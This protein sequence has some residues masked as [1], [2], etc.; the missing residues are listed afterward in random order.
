MAEPATIAVG[1]AFAIFTVI[2]GL[3]G[4]NS[5]NTVDGDVREWQ[6]NE[7]KSLIGLNF[8]GSASMVPTII[9]SVMGLVCTVSCCYFLSGCFCFRPKPVNI[10]AWAAKRRLLE[11]KPSAPSKSESMPVLTEEP[12]LPSVHSPSPPPSFHRL[13]LTRS[14]LP[15]DARCFREPSVIDIEEP[16]RFEE[17]SSSPSIEPITIASSLN[18]LEAIPEHDELVTNSFMVRSHTLPN[19][20]TFLWI[21]PCNTRVRSESTGSIVDPTSPLPQT[22]ASLPTLLPSLLASHRPRLQ[23]K[24]PA[25]LYRARLPTSPSK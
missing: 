24:V 11:S 13:S 5:S 3:L 16:P 10:M 8:F 19:K 1:C 7:S 4:L 23:Y 21:P 17:L 22:A 14:T 12:T 6:Q 18:S 25:L 20:G 9:F 15:K 2:I